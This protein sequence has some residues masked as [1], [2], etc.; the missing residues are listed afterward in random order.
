M[1]KLSRLPEFT[2]GGKWRVISDHRDESHGK[3]QEINWAFEH[4]SGQID[5]FNQVVICSLNYLFTIYI[6]YKFCLYFVA[7][8]RHA[9]RGIFVCEGIRLL[10]W[11]TANHKS[12]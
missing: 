3:T 4:V 5:L 9:H 1:L 6:K 10:R 2:H 11:F 12:S 8:K 7:D